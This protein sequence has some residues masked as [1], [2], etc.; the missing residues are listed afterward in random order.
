L[1]R[2]GIIT[3]MLAEANC[4]AAQS[5]PKPLI[6]CAGPGPGRANACAEQMLAE[7]ATTLMSFGLAGGLDPLLQPG[8]LVLSQT[9]IAADGKIHE[10]D[11]TWRRTIVER[12]AGISRTKTGS[13]LTVE[14]PITSI[15]EKRRLQEIHGAV[16]VDMESAGVAAAADAAGVPFLGLRAIADPAGRA[17]PTTALDGLAADG[18]TRPTAVLMGLL[19]RPWELAALC[20]VA[21]DSRAGLESLRRVAAVDL[22]PVPV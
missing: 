14:R 12:I 9:V 1:N 6:L 8:D 7:G 13:M 2:L 20:R 11:D 16:S 22:S 15:G 10:A 18:T 3:G 4:L 5:E 17:L 21:R 19:I